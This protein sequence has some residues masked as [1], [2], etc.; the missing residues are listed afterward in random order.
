MCLVVYL[1]HFCIA[2]LKALGKVNWYCEYK[3]C[4]KEFIDSNAQFFKT[5]IRQV[6]LQIREC[7]L[8]D[9][10]TRVLITIQTYFE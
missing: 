9:I 2:N 10:H 8:T 7:K 4:F 5:P 1:V 6:T 3:P